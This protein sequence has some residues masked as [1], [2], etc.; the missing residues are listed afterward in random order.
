MSR[1]TIYRYH[2]HFLINI[3]THSIAMNVVE[4]NNIIIIII[5]DDR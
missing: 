3:T 5:N 4:H 1:M 2:R